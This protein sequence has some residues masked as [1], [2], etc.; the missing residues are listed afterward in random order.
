MNVKRDIVWLEGL[1][2]VQKES[3]ISCDEVSICWITTV[4]WSWIKFVIAWDI[5][6]ISEEVEEFSSRFVFEFSVESSWST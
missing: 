3:Q 1:S 2:F 5:Q 4:V 6:Y